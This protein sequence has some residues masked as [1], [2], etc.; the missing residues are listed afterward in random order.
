MCV[1]MCLAICFIAAF[2]SPAVGQS[3][4][5]RAPS[6]ELSKAIG[7]LPVAREEAARQRRIDPRELQRDQHG[8]DPIGQ[9]KS[10]SGSLARGEPRL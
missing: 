5:Y 3:L 10:N 8:L 9:K 1:R 7:I 4:N 2:W 6:E